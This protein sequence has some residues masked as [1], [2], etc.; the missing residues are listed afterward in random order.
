MIFSAPRQVLCGLEHV[1]VHLRSVGDAVT[2]R[3]VLLTAF[4]FLASRQSGKI[5][6]ERRTEIFLPG[7][8]GPSMQR[9]DDS[10]G[11]TRQRGGAPWG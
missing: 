3:L 9:R 8:A 6:Q 4:Q 7:L 10:M 2:Y 5:W 11:Y 1:I